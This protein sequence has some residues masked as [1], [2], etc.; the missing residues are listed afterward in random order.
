LLPVVDESIAMMLESA[1]SKG[2]EI[3][4]VIPDDLVV[5]ADSNILQ[6]VIRN[7]VSNAVKFTPKGGK[8]SV[9]AKATGDK[10]VQISI[11]DT[12]IGMSP[13]MVDN[14]FR[15][16]VQT[17]R[18]GT[19]GE[20]STGLGLMLCKEFVEKHGGKIWVESEEGKGSVFYFIIPYKAVPEVKTAIK[21]VV[22]E[23]SAENQINPEGSGLKILIAEDDQGSAKIITM[24]VKTI[25]K[26]IL[27]VRTGVEAVAACRNNPDIDLVL[28][29]IQM[30]DMDGYEATRQIR[31]FNTD[32]VIIAQTAYALTGDREKSIAAGCNDYISKPI[33]KDEFMELMQKYFQK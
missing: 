27:K 9:S 7:L 17:N 20:P 29:D 23:N 31:K 2:I 6:T 13:K 26:E 24:A 16:D 28:M 1:K 10:G 22:L 4:Y 21:N 3:A 30:P 5:F 11:K 12:G 25:S 14:L 33:K 19:D 18:K 32:V 8:I 15:L